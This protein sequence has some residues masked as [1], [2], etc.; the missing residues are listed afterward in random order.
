MKTSQ[1]PTMY[2]QGDV[3]IRR[4]DT[5]PEAA[6]LADSSILV[7]GKATGHAHR[8]VGGDHLQVIDMGRVTAQF[9]RVTAGFAT[10]VH[11]E[12]ATVTLP[13][14]SYEI[15]RQREYRP[16]APINVAD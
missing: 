16:E 7:H 6:E 9:A 2:R 3:L 15:S 4:V 14:G 11:E 13:P 8:L 1:L 5:I 10:I 12:H